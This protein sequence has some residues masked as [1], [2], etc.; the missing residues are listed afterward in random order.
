[1]LLLLLYGYGF[2]FGQKSAILALS[3]LNSA[4]KAP[5]KQKTLLR[6]SFVLKGLLSDLGSYDTFI[7]TN[8]KQ[9][10]CVRLVNV[11]SLLC[12]RCSLQAL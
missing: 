8:G 12:S 6:S 5:L 1:M 3:V 9:Y 10:L 4:R 2:G 7:L 11:Q